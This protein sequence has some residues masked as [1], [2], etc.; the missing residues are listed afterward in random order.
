MP[1][2][3]KVSPLFSQYILDGEKMEETPFSALYDC[4]DG[5]GTVDTPQGP[6]EDIVDEYLDK[7]PTAFTYD[8]SRVDEY[9]GKILHTPFNKRAVDIDYPVSWTKA[10]INSLL[11]DCI[12]KDGHF[13]LQD[14][15]L[16]AKWD[17]NNSPAGNMAAFYDSTVSAGRYLFDLGIKLD[18]YFVEENRHECRFL[19]ETRNRMSSRR[20]CPDTMTGS[21]TD[22]LLYIP[23]DNAKM[24][25]G[26]S[27]LSRIIGHGSGAELEMVDPDYFIDCYE[28]VRELIEDGIITAGVPVG[29]GGL[30]TAAERFR[31]RKGLRMDIKGIMSA[32]GENDIVKI[33]F[34]ELPGVLV[35]IKDSD[36]DYV[37]SQ[38][39]LQD[40]AYFPI[41]HPGTDSNRLE[42]VSDP[43]NGISGILESLLN[44]ASEG[45]D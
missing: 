28:I 10:A 2:K 6:F 21:S 40:T 18:R 36:Y 3:N 37:D 14:I 29:R 12:F 31:G 22:W 4:L 19:L 8:K 26:G 34:S 23:F 17:W 25:L 7:K 11:L 30:A 9:V 27:A 20:K 24:T 45:E 1:M 38:L 5:N 39:L 35:Q 13:S 16:M 15:L 32:T 44:Q 41:G 42:V 33:L 43:S